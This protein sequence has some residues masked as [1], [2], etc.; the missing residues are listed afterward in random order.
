MV[1]K[2]CPIWVTSPDRDR[3]RDRDL[4]SANFVKS[5]AQMSPLVVTANI[6]IS[7]ATIPPEAGRPSSNG[8]AEP[9]C[10]DHVLRNHKVGSTCSDAGLRLATARSPGS[11][12]SPFDHEPGRMDAGSRNLMQDLCETAIHA[13]EALQSPPPE[14]LVGDAD[15][16]E[17]RANVSE[18]T[19]RSAEL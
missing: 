8:F 2:K 16:F 1:N 14:I 7:R 9:P 15:R 17:I 13:K 4:L 6:W 5:F 12:T 18:R 11:S 10:H 3:D 19:A